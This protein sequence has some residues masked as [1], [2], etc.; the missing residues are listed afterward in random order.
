MTL[1]LGTGR[2]ESARLM[3][4]ITRLR[5]SARTQAVGSLGLCFLLLLAG[6]GRL[7]AQDSDS[8]LFPGPADR[9][10]PAPSET[11][12]LTR[13]FPVYRLLT[14]GS[15]DHESRGADDL[16]LR[17]TEPASWTQP[18]P[19]HQPL[20]ADSRECE[21]C[22][23]FAAPT[24][25]APPPLEQAEAEL[26]RWAF[27]ERHRLLLSTLIPIMELALVTANSLIGYDTDHGFQVTHEGWF[28][29]NT[30]NGGADKASHL[31]DYS[32]SRGRDAL[33]PE[34]RQVARSE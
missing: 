22:M 1:A 27:L 33:R 16:S 14:Q 24:M 13:S 8:R 29:P 25:D 9:G 3:V 17:A 34:P 21:R 18:F 30:T 7:A 28:G 31:T 10:G 12:S 26:P 19:T 4:R 20:S 6:P 11:A 23:A 5:E 2:L 15:R 32:R